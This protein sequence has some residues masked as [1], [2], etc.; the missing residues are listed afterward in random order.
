MEC[1]SDA[2]KPAYSEDVMLR[3]LNSIVISNYK[4]NFKTRSLALFLSNRS[5]WSSRGF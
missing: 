4:C 2:V 3:G 5:Q 1:Y